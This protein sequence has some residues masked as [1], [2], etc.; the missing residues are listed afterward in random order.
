MSGKR[1]SKLFGID[2]VRAVAQEDDRLWYV[3]NAA[4]FD[5][6]GDAGLQKISRGFSSRIE[7]EQSD[8]RTK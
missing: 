3:Y 1:I 8:P 4:D 5:M 6:A 7:A 2:D